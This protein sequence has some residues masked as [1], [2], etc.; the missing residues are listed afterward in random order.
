MKFTAALIAAAVCLG[1]LA[2]AKVH[3]VGLKKIP[4]EDRTLVL[5][6]PSPHCEGHE[7]TGIGT[8][9]WIYPTFETK[10]HGLWPRHIKAV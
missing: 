5:T 2:D 1:G 9:G 6:H 10:V 7:F 3:K 4:K 8:Y